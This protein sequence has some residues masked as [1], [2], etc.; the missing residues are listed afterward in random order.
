MLI[1]KDNFLIAGK[2]DG[3][4]IILAILAYGRGSSH[5]DG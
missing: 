2:A 3:T 4:L 5:F 1:S